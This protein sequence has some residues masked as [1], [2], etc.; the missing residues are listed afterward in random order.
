MKNT[1]ASQFRLLFM[2][3][4]MQCQISCAEQQEP[5]NAWITKHNLLELSFCAFEAV[6]IGGVKEICR[7]MSTKRLLQ[8]S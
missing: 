1:N 5:S 6:L 2:L 3:K 7:S 4:K 8:N